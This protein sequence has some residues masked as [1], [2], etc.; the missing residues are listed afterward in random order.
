[1][2]EPSTT[3]T[4]LWPQLLGLAILQ[5]AVGL[6]WQIYSAAQPSILAKFDLLAAAGALSLVPGLVSLG[7]EPF[8]GK[9]SDQI[10]QR[11]GS[12]LP[13]INVGVLLTALI[14]LTVAFSL[15]TQWLYGV[16]WLIPGLMVAWVTTMKIF[17]NPSVALVKQYTPPKDLPQAAAILTIVGAVTGAVKPFARTLV[18]QFGA[19]LTFALGGAVLLTALTVLHRLTP[20][21]SRAKADTTPLLSHRQ[22]AWL[23]GVGTGVQLA[24]GA[25]LA[26]LPPRLAPPLPQLGLEGIASG[27]LLVSGVAAWPLGLWMKRI[28]VDRMLGLGL[29]GAVMVTLLALWEGGAVLVIVTIL[30][31][32]VVLGILFNIGVPLA[33]AR[34]PASQASFAIGLFFSGGALA[35]IF[36]AVYKLL[37]GDLPTALAVLATSIGLMVAGGCARGLKVKSEE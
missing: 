18:A 32:G 23:F 17:Q 3:S 6:S 21:T 24:L 9:F 12:R 29:L 33:L 35:V 16:R 13:A 19:S 26:A 30:V 7:L 14:F 8:F 1:M 28:G 10:R 15:Q 20:K 34:A 36:F 27:L 4:T 37:F 5:T 22:L 31:G 11:V 25:L 2:S